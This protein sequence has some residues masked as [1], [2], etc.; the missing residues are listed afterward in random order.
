METQVTSLRAPTEPSSATSCFGTT[1]Q[2]IPFVPGGASGVRARTRW[3]MFGAR[4][5]SPKL[6]KIFV[7]EIR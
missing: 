4:S 6:M 2:E 7:P 1:K 5:C 3:T